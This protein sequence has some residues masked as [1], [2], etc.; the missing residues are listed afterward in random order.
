MICKVCVPEKT[1][2]WPLVFI[3]GRPPLLKCVSLSFEILQQ[4][5]IQVVA[6]AP[7]IHLSFNNAYTCVEMNYVTQ[8]AQYDIPYS[9]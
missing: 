7:A 8:C 6:A 4:T 5:L 2:G 3:R 1:N 9:T